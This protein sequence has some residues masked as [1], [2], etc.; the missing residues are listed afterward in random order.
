VEARDL[1]R[2][3]RTKQMGPQWQIHH[4]GGYRHKGYLGGYRRGRG[5]VRKQGRAN[6]QKGADQENQTQSYQ[7]PTP[8]SPG[9]RT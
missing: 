6:Y 3:A 8:T 2:R 7:R 5:R 1:L 9:S 4:L